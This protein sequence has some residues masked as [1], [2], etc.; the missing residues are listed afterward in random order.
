[1]VL[2]MPIAAAIKSTI[3]T[4][5]LPDELSLMPDDQLASSRLD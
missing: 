2:A 4:M 1:V 5:R 3:E